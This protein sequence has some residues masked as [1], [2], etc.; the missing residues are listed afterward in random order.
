MRDLLVATTRTFRYGHCWITGSAPVRVRKVEL[1]RPDR[2][3]PG[4]LLVPR[5]GRGPW[6]TWIVL[7][8]ITRLGRHHHALTRFI[9][10]LGSSGAAVLVPEVPEWTD[11]DVD[12]GVTTPTVGASVR[13]LRREGVLVPG[14]RVG[15]IGF[16]F[17]SPQALL[18]SVDPEVGPDVGAV[19][20][21]G[22]YCDLE[23]TLRFQLTGRHEWRGRRRTLAP[24]PYGR[25]VVAANFLPRTRGYANSGEVADALRAMAREAGDRGLPAWDPSYDPYKAELRERLPPGDRSLFDLFAAASNQPAPLDELEALVEP[26]AH[27]ASQAE[28]LMEP[29]PGVRDVTVPVHLLHGRNDRLIPYT[30]SLRMG[31][32]LPAGVASRVT[33]TGLF[34]HSSGDS[35]PGLFRGLREALVFCG[36]LGRVLAAV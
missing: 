26:L 36:A 35:A 25:W 34:A 8:G 19:V 20:G 32:C 6:P 31:E 17:G 1:H 4:T 13:G 11:L 21:F 16:S 15:L 28:P 22:G 30:E 10:A 33:V 14:E 12:P 18:T 3:V 2:T 9:R 29:R 27:A 5:A 23:R 24:D 7:H